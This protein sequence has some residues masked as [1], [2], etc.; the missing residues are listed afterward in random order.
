MNIFNNSNQRTGYALPLSIFLTGLA[1]TCAGSW[2]LHSEIESDTRTEFER[3][4]NR[5]EDEVAR[6]FRQ[7]IYGLN[8]AKG[9]Y[10]ASASVERAEFRAY[11]NSLD[12]LAE[13]PG[14]R[15]LGFIQSVKR[16]DLA[17]FVA[18]ERKDEAPDFKVISLAET[19][20]DDLYVI[21]FIEPL[22]KNTQAVGLD[23]ASE[24]RR[25]AGAVQ[26]ID[27]GKPTITE[28]ISLLQADKATPGVLLYL[29]VYAPGAP[30]NSVAE[31]RASLLGMV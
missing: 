22:A 28:P 17:T 24:A 10:A 21:K 31:R 8:G 16:K 27:T 3:G 23:V 19:E 1:L 13:F 25:R 18:A 11:V 14:V 30:V 9:V 29:P 15:G 20:R 7:P 26:A 2:W 5:I 12:V 4:A 6:R